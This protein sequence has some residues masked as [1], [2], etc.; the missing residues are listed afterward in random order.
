MRKLVEMLLREV[1]GGEIREAIING[2]GKQL[3]LFMTEA[4]AYWRFSKDVTAFK[5]IEKCC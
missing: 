2:L 3:K 4:K 1:S 5:V